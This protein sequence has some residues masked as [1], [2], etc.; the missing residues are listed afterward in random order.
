MADDA[1]KLL[2][3]KLATRINAV[4]D[5]PGIPE[6]IEGAAIEATLSLGLGFL[7]PSYLAMVQSAADGIDDTEAASLTAWLT[8]LMD[9]Y[10]TWVPAMFHGTLAGVIV[11]L[12]R[13]G[14]EI[15]VE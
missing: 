13:K 15:I 4:V 9:Q 14:S 12:L 5:I 10:G 6:A 2:I 7:P 8:T 3:T 11:S 1:T